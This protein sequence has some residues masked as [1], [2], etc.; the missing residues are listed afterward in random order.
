[1]KRQAILALAAACALAVA[2]PLTGNAKDNDHNH[3]NAAKDAAVDFG[4][5]SAKA[6]GTIVPIGPPPCAQTLTLVGGP[7]DPC[8]Y[9]LHHLTPEET[10]ISK[11]GEVTFQ[12]HGGGHGIAIYPVSKN[13]T[14]DEIGQFM[15]AGMD[16]AKIVNPTEHPCNAGRVKAVPP[17]ETEANPAGTANANAAHNI[18]DGKGNVVI[19]VSQ[20]VTNAF[21]DNRVWYTPGRL[22]SVGGQQF[23]NGGTIP[24]SAGA[25]SN[26]Q[27]VTYRFMKTGR[28]L[29]ICMNRSHSMNDWM[30]GFVNVVDNDDD[31]DHGDNDGH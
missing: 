14:R 24:A 22:M 21:P 27:L 9:K 10:T 2:F 23:L 15:C 17:P 3:A 7:T 12:T 1:M 18:A 6:D 5:L 30:F 4:V 26:G 29:V 19:V 31:D 13:T 25:A 8:S 28:Y 20:N 11:G 16:P